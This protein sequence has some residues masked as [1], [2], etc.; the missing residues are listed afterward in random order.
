MTAL[1]A[2]RR[3]RC[4]KKEWSDEPSRRDPAGT[5]SLA[6]ERNDRRPSRR[7]DS[8]AH[9]VSGTTPHHVAHQGQQ[10]ARCDAPA[11]FR[12]RFSASLCLIAMM[13]L[14]FRRFARYLRS[15]ASALTAVAGL[16]AVSLVL[17]HLDAGA[18]TSGWVLS[19]VVAAALIPVLPQGVPV[20]VAAL[21]AVVVGLT[22][23]F[24]R[25]SRVDP[26]G[27]SDSGGYADVGE[28]P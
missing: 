17:V 25:T 18:S 26:V 6:S 14:L 15:T 3:S 20:L 23:L 8:A 2:A 11:H 5:A 27:S 24:G 13:P 21:V 19:G 16:A 12:A 1:L 9:G 22:D 7:R 4:G 28:K 10:G